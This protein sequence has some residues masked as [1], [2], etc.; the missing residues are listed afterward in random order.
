MNNKIFDIKICEDDLFS[1]E[2]IIIDHIRNMRVQIYEGKLT[3]E[4][5]KLIKQTI[6][7]DKMLLEKLK[8]CRFYNLYTHAKEICKND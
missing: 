4:G 7:N 1:I 8:I 5:E 3:K 2:A 6:E